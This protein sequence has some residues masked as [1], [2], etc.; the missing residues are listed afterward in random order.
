M[1]IKFYEVVYQLKDT[2]NV[3]P[4]HFQASLVYSGE[5][6]ASI[7]SEAEN[8]TQI[9]VYDDDDNLIATYFN[10]TDVVA[11]SYGGN[12][13]PVVSVEF[14]NIDMQGSD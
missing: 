11:V 10:Y 14:D 6:L 1:K 9:D 12:D 13:N 8:S 7:I 3:Q 2:P 4:S 5:T